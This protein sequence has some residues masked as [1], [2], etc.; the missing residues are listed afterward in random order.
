MNLEEAIEEVLIA[1]EQGELDPSAYFSGLA[2]TSPEVFAFL[3]DEDTRLLIESEHD[4]LLFVAMVLLECLKRTGKST[5]DLGLEDLERV[6][7]HNWGLL[8]YT[9]IDNLTDSLE[10]YEAMPLYEF[11]EDACTP[12]EDHDVLSAVAVELAYVKCKT[13]IDLSFRVTL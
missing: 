10:G 3:F 4:Y 12:A 2:T 6:A 13:L 9:S 11:L 7:D 1:S 5:E 8:E